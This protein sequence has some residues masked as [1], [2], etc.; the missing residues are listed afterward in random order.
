MLNATLPKVI[1]RV[2]YFAIKALEDKYVCVCVCVCHFLIASD[3]SSCTRS[4][5]H[6][7]TQNKFNM[8][9]LLSD[10]YLRI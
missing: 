7:F 8:I 2:L 6:G 1:R 5:I 3:V 9:S 10:F 4:S